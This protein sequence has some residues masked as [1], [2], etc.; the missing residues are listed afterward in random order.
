MPKQSHE[1][2]AEL[3]NLIAKDGRADFVIPGA[4]DRGEK[5][6]IVAHSFNGKKELALV[7]EGKDGTIRPSLADR[8]DPPIIKILTSLCEIKGAFGVSPLKFG[9]Y[10]DPAS[11]QKPNAAI[12]VGPAG[13]VAEWN[14]SMA[15]IDRKLIEAIAAAFRKEGTCIPNDPTSVSAAKKA[16]KLDKPEF[17]DWVEDILAGHGSPHCAHLGKR[18]GD[19]SD[20]TAPIKVGKNLF[21][22]AQQMMDTP[23]DYLIGS[24]ERLSEIRKHVGVPCRY[25]PVPI[26]VNGKMVMPEEY[27]QVANRLVNSTAYLELGAKIFTNAKNK[28]FS[29]KIFLLK[30]V[31]SALSDSESREESVVNVSDGPT[32]SSLSKNSSSVTDSDILNVVAVTEAEFGD[33]EGPAQ[34]RAKTN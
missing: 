16:K 31:V 2:I 13:D 17:I 29:L 25:A 28:V 9:K 8:K 1:R 14:A 4:K 3:N 21:P 27:E 20:E 22:E 34:K 23:Y 7:V 24:S 12:Y 6:K 32:E 11:S 26:Y 30:I 19:R 5:L 15:A 18:M 10:F 33:D